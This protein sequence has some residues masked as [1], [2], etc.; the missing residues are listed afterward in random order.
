MDIALF[1]DLLETTAKAIR[2]LAGIPAAQRTKYRDVL[3]ETFTLLDATLNMVTIRLGN[4]VLEPLDDQMVHEAGALANWQEWENA[5]RQLGLCHALRTAVSEAGRVQ[6]NLVASISIAEWE[7]LKGQMNGIL[8]S[9]GAL[10]QYI[11]NHFQEM[12]SVASNPGSVN[13]R[14]LRKKLLEFRQALKEQRQLLLEQE[15]ELLALV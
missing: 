8:N 14:E 10:A 5:E 4:I 9:E 11:T 1:K 2:A 13:P 12:W 6:S 15:R 7:D 3:D